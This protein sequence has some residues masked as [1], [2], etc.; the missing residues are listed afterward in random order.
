LTETTRSLRDRAPGDLRSDLPA[1][2]SVR[3]KPQDFV[4]SETVSDELLELS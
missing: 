1:G 3:F 4:A 2:D